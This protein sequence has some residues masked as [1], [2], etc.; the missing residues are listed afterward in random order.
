MWKN[1]AKA[2]RAKAESTYD[3]RIIVNNSLV[4]Y[5]RLINNQEL[6]KCKPKLDGILIAL[7]GEYAAGDIKGIFTIKGKIAYLIKQYVFHSYRKPL[8]KLIK[9]G[10]LR[11]K[12]FKKV[13]LLK[14]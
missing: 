11:L 10:Y 9:K 6:I 8:L 1:I 12:S 4:I 13:K 14:L 7:G 3:W 5:S 2:A